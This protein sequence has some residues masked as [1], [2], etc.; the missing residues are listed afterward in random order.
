MFCGA[1][2]I[3]EE[4]PWKRPLVASLRNARVL[5][6]TFLGFSPAW[7]GKLCAV[8]LKDKPKRTVDETP[9]SRTEGTT[10]SILEHVMRVVF[11]LC[12]SQK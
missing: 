1:N 4:W 9:H 12:A 8:S 6:K 7:R 10:V 2:S 3:T 5:V 11:W